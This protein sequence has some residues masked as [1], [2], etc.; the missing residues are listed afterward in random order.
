MRPTPRFTASSK[1][2]T[3]FLAWAQGSR[4]RTGVREA[5]LARRRAEII[6]VASLRPVVI[7]LRVSSAFSNRRSLVVAGPGRRSGGPSLIA[8]DLAGSPMARDEALLENVVSSTRG[9]PRFSGV[10]DD[11]VE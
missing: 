2:V 1:A 10:F 11:C 6:V 7:V 3:G 5:R 8:S 9:V 4:G